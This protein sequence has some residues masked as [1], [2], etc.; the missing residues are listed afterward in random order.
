MSL[1]NFPVLNKVNT[2]VDNAMARG[3]YKTW[4][5]Y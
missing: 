4:K 5:L 2:A 3:K 1:I